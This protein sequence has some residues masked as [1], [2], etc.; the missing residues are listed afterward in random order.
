M[1]DVFGVIAAVVAL[2]GLIVALLHVGYLAMLN[3]AA[4]R[5]G[6]A[7]ASTTDYVKGRWAVAGGTT[8]AAAIGL[9]LTAAPA[10]VPDVLGLVLAGGAGVVAKGALDSTRAHFRGNP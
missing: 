6:I 5:K 8:A 1:G 3:N 4:K 10:V 2:I 7:G 9:L